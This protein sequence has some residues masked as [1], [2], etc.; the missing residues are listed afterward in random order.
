LSRGEGM[1]LSATNVSLV[2]LQMKEEGKFNPESV[3]AIEEIANELLG[4]ES[5]VLQKATEGGV[6]TEEWIQDIMKFG[7]EKALSAVRAIKADRRRP[8]QLIPS[9][10]EMAK[11]MEE[12]LF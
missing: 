6:S 4:P 3:M 9:A 10:E 7:L 2:S 5:T 1:K 11:A 8:I 12:G